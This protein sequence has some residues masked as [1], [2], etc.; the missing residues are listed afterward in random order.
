MPK[1]IPGLQDSLLLHGRRIFSEKGYTHT[2]LRDVAASAGTSVGN[3]YNYYRSKPHLFLAVVEVWH[4]E[5]SIQIE[6]ILAQTWEPEEKLF[7]IAEVQYLQANTVHGLWK[8]FFMEGA[9]A[10]KDEVCLSLWGKM[11]EQVKLLQLKMDELFF[12]ANP[13]LSNMPGESSGRWSSVLLTSVFHL[14]MKYPKEDEEN[15]QFIRNLIAVI[16]RKSM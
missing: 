13:A 4:G 15:L 16:A 7:R 9:K 11:E 12:Q 14:P 2:E 5:L 3:I 1:I 10:F 8:E 6:E